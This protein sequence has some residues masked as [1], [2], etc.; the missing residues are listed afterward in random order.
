MAMLFSVGPLRRIVSGAKRATLVTADDGAR[1]APGQVL[2]ARLPRREMAV[3]IRIT[4]VR[5]LDTLEDAPQAAEQAGLTL[6]DFTGGTSWGDYLSEVGR[7]QG[8]SVTLVVFEAAGEV[9]GRLPKPKPQQQRN[10]AD[11]FHGRPWRRIQTD[12]PPPTPDTRIHPADQDELRTRVAAAIR[13]A[14]PDRATV[15]L[16]GPLSDAVL[17]VGFATATP[18]K[19]CTLTSEQ[20]QA[21]LDWLRAHKLVA[22][23]PDGPVLAP[24]LLAG[25]RILP[26]KPKKTAGQ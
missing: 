1:M 17:T 12:D 20:T 23:H 22:D 13:Q 7:H 14:Q 18:T 4:G 5:P 16:L 2:T 24:K 19:R 9:S 8:Q 10:S 15:R 25:L 6:A 3:K 21:A 11:S 26:P